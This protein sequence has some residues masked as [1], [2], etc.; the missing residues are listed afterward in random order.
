MLTTI[1]ITLILAALSDAAEPVVVPRQQQE[2]LVVKIIDTVSPAKLHRLSIRLVNTHSGVIWGRFWS[3][4]VFV[5]DLSEGCQEMVAQ[6]AAQAGIEM[7]HTVF[8]VDS[9]LFSPY[10]GRRI[11]RLIYQTIGAY[12][13]EKHDTLIVS[14]A[15][16]DGVTSEMADRTWRSLS[17]SH[18]VHRAHPEV[19]EDFELYNQWVGLIT[20][21]TPLFSTPVIAPVK[22]TEYGGGRWSLR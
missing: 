5:D 18:A 1:G 16:A 22:T 7:P 17:R 6:I 3:R 20:A 14:D 21:D 15:C 11:G 8:Q 9:D 12:V 10:W 19:E 13:F 2:S 4:E